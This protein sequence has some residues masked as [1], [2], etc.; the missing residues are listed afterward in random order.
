MAFWRKAIS[1]VYDQGHHSPAE[2]AVYT[3]LVTSDFVCPADNAY[4]GQTVRFG[5]FVVQIYYTTAELALPLKNGLIVRKDPACRVCGHTPK[6]LYP[7][8]L[9]IGHLHNNYPSVLTDLETVYLAIRGDA[10]KTTAQ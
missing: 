9:S 10:T 7:K 2:G 8:C 4:R 3:E 5:V 1:V 6:G